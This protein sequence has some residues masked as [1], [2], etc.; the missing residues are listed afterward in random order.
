MRPIICNQASNPWAGAVFSCSRLRDAS[1][2]MRLMLVGELD[3][4]T[5]DRARES[6]RSAQAESRELI[7][8]LGDIWF[9]DLSGL[10]VLIDA[11]THARTTMSRLIIANCP[12]IVPRMLHLLDLEDALE[13]APLREPAPTPQCATFRRHVS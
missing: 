10:R 8:D 7:C 5:A 6:L 1:G 11:T 3:L 4:V 9:V 2:A 12:S 13:I